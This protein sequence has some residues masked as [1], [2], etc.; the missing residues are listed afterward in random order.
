MDNGFIPDD[1]KPEP[2]AEVGSFRW[3]N[4]MAF[5]LALR[6]F[7]NGFPDRSMVV[8]LPKVLE[9]ELGYFCIERKPGGWIYF[10]AETLIDATSK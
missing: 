4:D 6:S 7:P 1:W 10:R 9:Y 3:K 2:D 8:R 5:Q